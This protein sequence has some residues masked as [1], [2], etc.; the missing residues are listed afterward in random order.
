MKP[1]FVLLISFLSTLL[2]TKKIHQHFKVDFSARIALSIMLCFTA[3]GHFVF[4]EGMVMM[5][6]EILPIKNQII[7][8]TGVFEIGAAFA[9]HLPKY[10]KQTAWVLI[11]FFIALLPANINAAMLNVDYQNATYTGTGVTYLWFRIPLQIL[12][13]LWTYFSGI[14]WIKI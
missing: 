14:K 10:R 2:V 12:F 13:I 9:I 3:I 7:Y 6:P 1:L 11:L 5:L 8:L 4:T